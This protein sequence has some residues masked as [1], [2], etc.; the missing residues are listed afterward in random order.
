MRFALL[1]NHADGLDMARALVES[2]RHE[3][4]VY[5]GSANGIETLR[6]WNLSPAQVGD[7]EEVLADPAIDVVIVAGSLDDRPEQLRRALQSERHVVCVHPAN[8]TPDTAYEAAMIQA[9]TGHVAFPLLPDAMHPAIRRLAEWIHVQNNQE[10]V[11]SHDSLTTAVTA[12]HSP[13]TT[14]HSPTIIHHSPL[15]THHSPLRMIEV[16]RWATDRVLLETET[17]EHNPSFP[18]W[19]VLRL[20]GGDIAEVTALAEE[21]EVPLAAPVVVSGRFE[22]GGMFHEV[23][24]PNQSESRWRL[25]VVAQRGRAELVFPHG[26]PGPARLSWSDERGEGSEAWETWNPWPALVATFEEAL[27][28]A[29]ALERRSAERA[30]A[31][32]RSRANLTWRDE[33]RCLELD[34]AA[35]RSIERRRTS[36]LEYQ[37]ATEEAG[38]KGTMTML[39]CGL[40]WFTLVLLI[41]SAWVP[42]MGWLIVPVLVFFLLMQL[43]RWIVPPA[44]AATSKAP[45]TEIQLPNRHAGNLQ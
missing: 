15:T 44:P 24:L 3:L 23:L 9:D 45:T 27:S 43:L 10:T 5:S 18:G 20:L 13:L 38:F 7:M 35:R 12:H 26:W 31:L 4:A 16:E 8:E 40:I 6:R 37:E 39:G 30:P 33:I 25:T 32:S 41:V 29:A 2:G 11:A 19:D 36:T 21:E 28:A 34:A 42:W 1:G 22:E 14:H 17:E